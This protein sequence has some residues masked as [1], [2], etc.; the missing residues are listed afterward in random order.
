[1]SD[2]DDDIEQVT[3]EAARSYAAAWRGKLRKGEPVRGLRVLDYDEGPVTAL[4]NLFEHACPCGCG[5]ARL[6]A[7]FA[8]LDLPHEGS[9]CDVPSELQRYVEL[10]I[11]E[12]AAVRKWREGG[13]P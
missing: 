3:I 6:A 1:M 7:A 8:Q 11:E 5:S 13:S 10:L 9:P 4:E 2:V 12:L